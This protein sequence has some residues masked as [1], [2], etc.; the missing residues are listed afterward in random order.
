MRGLRVEDRA[1]ALER[2]CDE[3]AADEL[4][5]ESKA[6][7]RTGEQRERDAH[8]REPVVGRA[9]PVLREGDHLFPVLVR[10]VDVHHGVLSPVVRRE[11]VPAYPGSKRLDE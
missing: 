3:S 7:L 9:D 6:E 2:A 1:W 5:R 11:R 8:D 10:R 4:P